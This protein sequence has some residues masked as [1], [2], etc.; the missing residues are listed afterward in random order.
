M[1]ITETQADED[2]TPGQQCTDPIDQQL[3]WVS[4]LCPGRPPASKKARNQMRILASLKCS[5][6]NL[7]MLFHF[8]Y[9]V[10]MVGL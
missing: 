1:V 8:A 2:Y 4:S 3:A 10:K 9:L 7:L 6:A 5:T